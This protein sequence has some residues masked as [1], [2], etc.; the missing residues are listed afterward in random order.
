MLRCRIFK[1]LVY[2]KYTA[3][4]IMAVTLQTRMVELV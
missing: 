3:L 2:L 1:M 4:F